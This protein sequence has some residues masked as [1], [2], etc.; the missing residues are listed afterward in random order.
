MSGSGKIIVT[1]TERN[2]TRKW[3]LS[4]AVIFFYFLL[5]P[6]AST[7]VSSVWYVLVWKWGKKVNPKLKCRHVKHWE[8]R[9]WKELLR[10]ILSIFP[11]LFFFV[12][13]CCVL[14]SARN[15]SAF[16]GGPDYFLNQE[17]MNGGIW[18]YVIFFLISHM[19]WLVCSLLFMFTRR[20][21][22][23]NER[24]TIFRKLPVFWEIC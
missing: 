24:D 23:K 4:S 19:I 8:C 16:E 13:I 17:A 1:N 11:S 20:F 10:S 9:S 14:I 18:V 22:I 5:F 15:F 12:G 2:T 7:R 3:V 21:G 6:I